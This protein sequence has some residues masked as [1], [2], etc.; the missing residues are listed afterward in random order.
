M[1]SKLPWKHVISTAGEF[2]EKIVDADGGLVIREGSGRQ[3]NFFTEEDVALVIRSVNT[4]H[5]AEVER[6]RLVGN[7]SETNAEHIRPDSTP[8]DNEQR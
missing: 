2:G 8:Q 4:A 1:H 5:F 7:A 3:D 6:A